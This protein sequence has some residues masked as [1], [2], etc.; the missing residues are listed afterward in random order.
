MAILADSRSN[1]LIH[2][3]LLGIFIFF[4]FLALAICAAFIQEGKR[5]YF[6]YYFDAS[7]L[8]VAASVFGYIAG[9]AFLMFNTYRDLYR[10]IKNSLLVELITFSVL[11]IL[12]LAGAAALSS[13]GWQ[14]DG[15]SKAAQ[16][17]RATLAFA[18]L[19]TITLMLLL[20][21]LLTWILLH[22]RRRL[23]ISILRTNIKEFLIDGDTSLR[24]SGTGMSA[25]PAS[26]TGGARV[27]EA[28]VAVTESTAPE[29]ARV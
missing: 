19:S 5:R 29:A 20:A 24:A 2:L 3:A 1:H 7:G 17:G 13:D 6:G 28:S 27:S 10:G 18:W 15:S 12:H 14:F 4:D 16:L 26:T 22:R 23:E 25:I 21:F 8:I 11:F 9:F